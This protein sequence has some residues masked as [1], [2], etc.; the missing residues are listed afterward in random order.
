VLPDRLTCSLD[1]AH[2]YEASALAST[3]PLDGAP[4]LATYEHPAIDR[5][6]VA[7]RA[8]T[9]W[10]YREVLPVEG[11]A[12]PVTLGEGATPLVRCMRLANDVGIE[13]E[14]YVKDESQNP[15]ASFKSRGMAAA[16]TRAYALGVRSFVTPSAGNAGGAL[17][18]YAAR[19]GAQATIFFPNDTPAVLVEES[20]AFGA[21]VEL[22][23]GLIDFAGKRAAAFASETG[24][25]NVA[26]LREPYRIEGK[27]TMGYELVEELGRVPAAIVYPA[28]GGTGLI[29]MWKAFGE[30]ERAGWIGSERPK[31]FAVQ[32]TGCAPIVRAFERGAAH[33]EPWVD[34][35]TRAW[36]LRVPSALGDRLMLA[37]IAASGGG[38]LAV[39][40]AVMEADMQVMRSREGIDACEEGGATLAALRVLIARGERFDG[41]VVLFNTASALKYAPRSAVLA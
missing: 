5:A 24:A 3:C 37:A 17:A 39:D 23:D 31:M 29:G 20:R 2:R 8:A 35:R 16:V 30:L 13:A 14:L 32:A 18:A 4:L 27:K 33:A 25:F 36:G 15:T 1:G 9:M 7:Q 10:R 6:T 11:E 41:P 28:G 26:T 12:L 19:A 40:D 34:G 38:A 21:R 22:V